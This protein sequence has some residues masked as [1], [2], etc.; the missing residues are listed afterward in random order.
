M[1]IFFDSEGSVVVNFQANFNLSSNV[2]AADVKEEIIN[3]NGS[4]NIENFIFSSG[5]TAYGMYKWNTSVIV[6]GRG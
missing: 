6:V 3:Q 5:V 4:S 2:T 1:N